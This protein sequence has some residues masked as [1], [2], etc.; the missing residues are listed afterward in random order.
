MIHAAVGVHPTTAD[1]AAPDFAAALRELVARPGVAAI[2][3]TGL[4]YH[5][6]PEDEAAQR[7][8]KE[9]QAAVFRARSLISRPTWA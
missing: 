2:G 7:D 3:E 9:T 1:A 4:D 8:V 6:L 5:R